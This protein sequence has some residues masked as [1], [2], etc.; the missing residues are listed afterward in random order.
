MRVGEASLDVTRSLRNLRLTS[1]VIDEITRD[2]SEDAFQRAVVSAAEVPT[3][4]HWLLLVDYLMFVT[5]DRAEPFWDRNVQRHLLGVLTRDATA[6]EELSAAEGEH[7]SADSDFRNARVQLGR[8]RQ[9]YE[10][11]VAKVAGTGG[12]SEEL[13]RLAGMREGLN[14]RVAEIEQ[15]VAVARDG[16]TEAMRE[17][18]VA[19]AELAQARDEFEVAR[20]RLIEAAMPSQDDV[21]RYLS[22]RLATDQTCPWCGKEGGKLSHRA[23]SSA[24]CFL[25]GLPDPA[26]SVGNGKLAELETRVRQAET[27]VNANTTRESER[28]DRLRTLEVSLAARRSE[29]A[30]LDSRMNALRSQLPAGDTDLDGT[31]SFIADLEA[32]LEQLRTVLDASRA[33]LQRLIELSNQ[34]VREKQDDIKR[35]FDDVAT[36]FL[37]ERCQLVPHQIK[38]RIGQEGEQFEIQAFDLDLGSATEVGTSRRDTRN[39]VSESQRIFIDIAFRIA[40]IEACVTSGAGSLVVDAP[41][42]SLD[43]V[44]ST[45]AAT[46]LNAFVTSTNERRLVVA[47]NIVD[48]SML[49]RLAELAGITGETDPRII[50]LLDLAAP[51]AAVIERG[52]DY[53]TVLAQALAPR[54]RESP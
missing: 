26:R 42:G 13:V 29:R 14:T 7:V 34:A 3:Y 53:R 54:G 51:T 44:F 35:V 9:R 52:E 8:H 36:T 5:E 21:A 19:A 15:E 39:D 2:Q 18:E 22:V 17:G 48:G 11:Q 12:I 27:E 43:A 46:L 41:E 47:S 33:R 31:A 16:A 32:D 49:P 38:V 6:A 25:C 50:N 1:L 40:L 4:A 10:A 23:A 20:F 37:L 45:N 24:V 28:R 30:E